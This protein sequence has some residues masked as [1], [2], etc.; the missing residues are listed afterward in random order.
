MQTLKV[1]NIL[2]H[3][4]WPGAVAGG[5]ALIAF[6]ALGQTPLLRALGMAAVIFIMALTLRRLGAALAIIGGLALAFSPAFWSQVGVSTRETPL[7]P[8]AL[9]VIAGGAAALTWFGRKPSLI[10]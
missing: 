1:R 4:F 8:V 10:L 2:R 9:L 3:R 6:V 7:L 5:G